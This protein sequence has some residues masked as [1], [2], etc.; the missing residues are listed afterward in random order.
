MSARSDDRLLLA[1]LLGAGLSHELGNLLATASTSLFLAERDRAREDALV[2]HLGEARASLDR[3]FELSRRVLGLARGESPA[4]EPVALHALVAQGLR[5]IRDLET[6]V[7]VPPDLVAACDEVLTLRVLANLFANARNAK[8]TRLA[9]TG[10]RESDLVV[11]HIADDGSGIEA[12]K[13]DEVFQPLYT[14]G[15]TGLGLPLSRMLAEAQGG[16]LRAEPR[17][18]G[19]CLVLTLPSA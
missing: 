1:G 16:S 14:T 6:Q 19:A 18:T 17:E 9:V 8:A 10:S 2:R 12:S 3:A 7:K 5:D 15:G 13:T 11:L 4:R